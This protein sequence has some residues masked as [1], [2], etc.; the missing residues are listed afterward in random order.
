MAEGCFRG[1]PA[2]L[3]VKNEERRECRQKERWMRRL[4]GV[5]AEF[6]VAP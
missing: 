2:S 1:V 3:A 6:V 4:E 5:Q